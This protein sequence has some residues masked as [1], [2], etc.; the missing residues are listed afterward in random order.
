MDSPSRDSLK[1]E[2]S[3][4]LVC[5]KHLNV[6]IFKFQAI[7]KSEASM[8]D[9]KENLQTQMHSVISDSHGLKIEYIYYNDYILSN[10]KEF[11]IGQIFC[12]IGPHYIDAKLTAHKRKFINHNDL[13]DKISNSNMIIVRRTLSISPKLGKAIL[14]SPNIGINEQICLY[15]VP[16]NEWIYHFYKID[17]KDFGFCVIYETSRRFENINEM[18]T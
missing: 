2:I 13:N 17:E 1:S 18:N 11:K 10:S 15:P 8:A 16:V 5:C 6:N 14:K 9:L 4:L 12:G 3:I 7:V